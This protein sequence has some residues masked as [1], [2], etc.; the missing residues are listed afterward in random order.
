M[1][2][3]TGSREL[4]DGYREDE[5][6]VYK[7]W[8]DTRKWIEGVEGNGEDYIGLGAEEQGTGSGKLI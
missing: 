3:I 4:K 6:M 2:W 7:E 1:E 8:Q 5:D